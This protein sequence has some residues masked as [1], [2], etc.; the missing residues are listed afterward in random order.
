MI[1]DTKR[2]TLK[3]FLLYAA[4]NICAYIVSHAAYLFTNDTAGIMLEYIS[5][6][7]YKSVSFI[8]PPILALIALPTYASRGI[9]KAL[10]MISAIASARIFYTIPDFYISFFYDYSYNSTEAFLFSILAA[11]LTVAL[12][13]CG[14]LISI[15]A[16]AFVL[17]LSGGKENTDV[18]GE[19]SIL[20]DTPASADFLARHNIPI[21]TLVLLRLGFSLT[22][23]IIDTVLFFI[24]YKSN[25][26]VGEVSTILANYVI[27]FILTIVSYL[28]CIKVKNTIT[29]SQAEFSDTTP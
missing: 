26:T 9:K 12:T 16:I 29:G 2:I 5:Y 25:Y 7:L 3:A 15:A 19:L 28:A 6:Y 27:L 10:P 20:L 22:V 21:L 8:A 11:M 14:A 13:V 18:T 24:T 4:V 23:E 17:K 1:Q